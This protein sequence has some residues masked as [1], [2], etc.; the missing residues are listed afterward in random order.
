MHEQNIKIQ[1]HS[2]LSELMEKFIHE[3]QAC[4]YRY[5]RESHELLRLDR[6]LC[7]IGLQSPE[8]PRDIVDK[9]TAKRVYEKP[10]NQRLRII[11][12]RQFALCLRRQGIDAYVPETTK[13]AVK[14]IEFTPYIFNHQQVDKILQAVD[15]T[16]PDSRSPMRHLIMP[17]V[18]RLLYCCG[19]RVSE[20]LH[21][22]FSDV[23]LAAGTLTILKSKFNK[24]RLVPLA[25]TMTARLRKYASVLG[26]GDSSLIF[27]PT[28]Y[29]NPY[30]KGTVYHI[31]RQL[32][33]KCRIPHEG[34]GRGPRLHDLRHSFAVHKLESW[35]K[36][37]VDLGVKLPL[38]AA[39]M[40]HK[41]LVSTQRYLHLTPEIFPDIV[42]RLEKFVGDVI[43][44]RAEH[45]TN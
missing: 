40:G 16:P 5:K 19:M 11:R 41:N 33:W 18:F 32:L 24:D 35:Y 20:V 4:G 44:R 39:Y 8:L 6:F 28:A 26:E 38:L 43:P 29:G 37:G 3:K 27:F 31:F 1:C 14:R 30:S 42:N 7:K 22:K 12:I 23:N 45:E 10:S 2:P 34:R 15:S 36:Q 17:E 9:W 25:P 21:L 13:A